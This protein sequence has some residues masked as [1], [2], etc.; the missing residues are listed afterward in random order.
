[1]AAI[2]WQIGRA[3]R[4][5]VNLVFEIDHTAMA[6]LGPRG[7]EGMAR[8]ARNGS[9]L[10]LARAHGMGLDLEGLRDLHFRFIPFSAAALPSDRHGIPAWAETAR[11]AGDYGFTIGV[12]GL[13][14]EEQI[15]LASR[16]AALASGPA[17][18]PPR[19]VKGEAIPVH[20]IRSAA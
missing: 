16:W 19:R 3:G 7:I 20:Q 5:A 11:I 4:N 8:L 6:A 14:Y 10:A 18:A 13:F 1:L 9:G 15:N 2:E 17:F 12:Q